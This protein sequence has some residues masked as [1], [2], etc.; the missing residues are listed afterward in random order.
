MVSSIVKI[1]KVLRFIVPLVI[2]VL[3]FKKK[4]SMTRPYVSDDQFNDL[5]FEHMAGSKNE[6]NDWSFKLGF[7]PTHTYITSMLN[8]THR[9]K[10]INRFLVEFIIIKLDIFIK[11]P[12]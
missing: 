6:I 7:G 1:S 3:I 5:S 9:L 10:V 4:P 8:R 2:M 12:P 11:I